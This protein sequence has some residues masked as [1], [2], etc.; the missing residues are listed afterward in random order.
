MFFDGCSGPDLVVI[1]A[2]KKNVDDSFELQTTTF[3]FDGFDPEIP[4]KV[5]EMIS[6]L[7]APAESSADPFATAQKVVDIGGKAISLFDRLRN[8]P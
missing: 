4:T 1:V 8:K 6:E 5:K 3:G 2:V 7:M